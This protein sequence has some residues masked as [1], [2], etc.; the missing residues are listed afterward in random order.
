MN[1]I[2]NKEVT[3]SLLRYI[4]PDDWSEQKKVA[5][6]I[7]AEEIVEAIKDGKTVEIINAMIEGPFILK[8]IN[9][10]GKITIQRTKFRGQVDWSYAAFKQVLNL[11][12]STFETD[13]TFTGITVEKDIFQDNVTFFEKAT[14]SDITVN[15]VF[16][17]RDSTFKKDATFV[18]SIFK[19]RTEF[20]RSIF[21]GEVHFGITR[22]GS[23]AGFNGTKFKK[24]VYFNSAKIDGGTYFNSAIF[25]DEADFGNARIGDVAVFNGTKF[26]G[27][28]FNSAKIE[29]PVFFNK[30]YLFRWDNI[31]G[32]DN[33]KLIDF[34]TQD[35]GI[36][37]EKTNIIEKIE[38][39]R[40]IKISTEK[41]TLLLSL[42][43]EKTKVNLKIDDGRT[44]ELSAMLENGKLNIYKKTIFKGEADFGSTRI[45]NAA[46]FRETEFKEQVNFSSATI[47]G[48]ALFNQSIFEKKAIFIAARFGGNATFDESNFY[49]EATF[50]MAKI[51]GST[52]FHSVIFKGD[53]DF[54][55]VIIGSTAEFND[56]EF[57]QKASFNS[58]KIEGAVFF[59]S[60]IFRCDFDFIGVQNCL[61]AEFQNAAFIQMANFSF[62]HIKKHLKFESTIFNDQVKIEHAQIE[63]AISLKGAYFAKDVSFKYTSLGTFYFEKFHI[64]PNVK[65]D[66]RGCIY[67]DIDPIN[68][69]EELTEPV[70]LYP[71]DRQPFSQIEK[72]FRRAGK[73]D[74]ADNVYYKGRCR[75]F[76]ENIITIQ[77]PFIW[78]IRPLWLLKYLIS[79]LIFT[80]IIW[81]NR[82]FWLLK[83][84]GLQLLTGYG[85]R[86]KR[87]LFFIVLILLAG[88]YIFNQPGAVVLKPEANQT[89]LIWPMDSYLEAF[90]VSLNLFLPIEI[91]SGTFWKPSQNF[92][93]FGTLLK[94][95]GWI[96]VPIGVAG[97]SGLLKRSK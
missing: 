56:A 69:W 36:D 20:F 89:L 8:Y 3:H 32:K 42:N 54:S 17:S 49:Q 53:I 35:Y 16:Y 67:D 29:G 14:F 10:E 87:L 93:I 51:M 92:A 90:Y 74:L 61:A 62:A 57:N 4:C 77:K 80:G 72:T 5:N 68:S 84:G 96:L 40:T 95:A 63:E 60:A 47:E 18:G 78:I 38:T 37:W 59:R 21:E 52:K 34:I 66:L 48:E 44:D 76:S 28:N 19:K 1:E 64:Q 25:E 45:G 22:I 91:P 79:P 7:D 73:D 97:I 11:E 50:S 13:A 85:V 15:G 55:G 27:I 30:E 86:V 81:I 94:L 83:E 23:H 65:I 12:N 88:T 75:E 82:C 26:K 6:P 31:P 43:K 24:R 58:A 33:E 9:A 41:N 71:Y 2:E 46:E 70:H 39:D